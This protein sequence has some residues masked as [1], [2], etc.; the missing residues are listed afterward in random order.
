MQA[1]H[2]ITS[3]AETAVTFTLMCDYADYLADPYT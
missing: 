1:G 3:I 2:E